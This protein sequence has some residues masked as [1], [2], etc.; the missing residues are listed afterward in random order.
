[1]GRFTGARKTFEGV[2]YMRSSVRDY[3]VAVHRL[4]QLTAS[5]ERGDG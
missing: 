3:P 1:M 5:F 2:K 4:H